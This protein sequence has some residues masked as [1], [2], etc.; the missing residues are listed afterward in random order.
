[1]STATQTPAQKA[2]NLKTGTEALAPAAAPAPAANTPPVP[3]VAATPARKA[4]PARTVKAPVKSLVQGAAKVKT[5]VKAKPVKKALA[6]PVT[7]SAVATA[8]KPV[9]RPAVSVAAK[10]ASRAIKAPAAGKPLAGALSQDAAEKQAKGKKPKLVRD[11]FTMPKTEYAVIDDLKTRAAKLAMPVKK[12]ELLRAG[13]KA[14]A[15]MNDAAFA[16][17]LGNVP[18]I[19]TGRPKG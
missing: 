8:P 19:K 9:A 17:A 7:P 13:I 16:A 2:D 15:A 10:P 3:A 6:A 4:S 11:S 12:S 14:L 5:P 18:T 1:M